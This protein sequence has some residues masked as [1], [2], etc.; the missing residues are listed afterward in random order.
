MGD[1]L[2][3]PQLLVTP[4]GVSHGTFWPHWAQMCRLPFFLPGKEEETE[5]L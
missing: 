1:A 3:C 4:S 2:P 5:Q